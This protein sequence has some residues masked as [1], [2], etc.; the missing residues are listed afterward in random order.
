MSKTAAALHGLVTAPRATQASVCPPVDA[1]IPLTRAT[2]G[3][4]AHGCDGGKAA[5]GQL[6]AGRQMA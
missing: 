3:Y 4:R 2:P 6:A 5:A 1:K